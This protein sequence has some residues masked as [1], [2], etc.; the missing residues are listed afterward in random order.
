MKKYVVYEDK[1]MLAQRD[2]RYVEMRENKS[3]ELFGEVFDTLDEAKEFVKGIV[4]SWDKP[5]EVV[6]TKR[7]LDTVLYKS[8]W[9]DLEEYD[10]DGF[11]VD[12][13]ITV[14]SYDSLPDEVRD[15]AMKHQEGYWKFL[16]Y[17]ADSYA[18]LDV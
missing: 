16:D 14:E 6:R 1:M 4:E 11:V 3:A 18:P 7:G 5:Y 9:V 15:A 2:E 17:E 10:E 8:A 12:D 13:P